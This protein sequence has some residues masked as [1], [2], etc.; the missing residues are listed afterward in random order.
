MTFFL[1]G[2]IPNWIN[3]SLIRNGPGNLKVGDMRF[4]HLFDSSAHL[5][6]FAI[7]HGIITYQCRF[8][9]TETYKK[10]MTAKRIVVPEFGTPTVPDPCQSIF[11]RYIYKYR[12][13]KKEN[14][15]NLLVNFLKLYLYI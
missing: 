15:N 10:N 2:N 7:K 13:S 9:Q 5:H 8:I 6:K 4:E 14:N 3:G 11:Q 12:N 1:I